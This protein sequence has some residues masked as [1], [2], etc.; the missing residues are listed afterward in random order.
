M[1]EKV[2]CKALLFFVPSPATTN[3]C[4]HAEF[5]IYSIVIGQKSFTSHCL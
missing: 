3:H 4:Q 5:G 1:N 2:D